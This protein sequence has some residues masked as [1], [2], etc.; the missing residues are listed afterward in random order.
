[1]RNSPCLV[2]SD[3]APSRSE[4]K[5]LMRSIL[6]CIITST[7]RYYPAA[8]VMVMRHV[9]GRK[10]RA[11]CI[12]GLNVRYIPIHAIGAVGVGMFSEWYERNHIK[13]LFDIDIWYDG[14][15][16]RAI[17]VLAS[18]SHSLETSNICSGQ[19]SSTINNAR[20]WGA[21]IESSLSLTLILSERYYFSFPL[22]Y[23]IQIRPLQW[24][25][26]NL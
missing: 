3:P 20:Y 22:E 12:V 26:P 9:T 23:I 2:K 1:M 8:E 17:V 18:H 19:Y 14:C 21:R 7:R 5:Y 16:P 25:F 13:C 4:N 11:S 24:P 6:R 15:G 10:C